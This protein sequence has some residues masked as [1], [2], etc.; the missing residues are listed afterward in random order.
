MM[1]VAVLV[2]ALLM[3]G[4][5]AAAQ[6]LPDKPVPLHSRA[7]SLLMTVDESIAVYDAR[8]T[9]HCLDAGTCHEA[10]PLAKPFTGN[11]PHRYLPALA[12][13]EADTVAILGYR[14]QTS[15]HGWVRKVWWMPQV[16]DI[17]GHAA[18]VGYT[19]EN[20]NGGA[21]TNFVGPH[22]RPYH[23]GEK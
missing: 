20:L 16:V 18:A 8:E 14:M 15:R 3:L 6:S 13:S 5:S 11:I 4:L 21:G 22:P 9:E 1:R 12:M 19:K 17:L 10:D 23:I 2:G 7:W